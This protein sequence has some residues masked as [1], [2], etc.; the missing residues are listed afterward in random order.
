MNHHELFAGVPGVQDIMQTFARR[1]AGLGTMPTDVVPTKPATRESRDALVVGGGP[2]GMSIAN[3]LADRGAKIL[4]I[5]EGF[6]AGGSVLAMP[7]SHASAFEA[8][9]LRFEE[10]V[11]AARIELACAHVAG[12][13][14]G[15]DVLV[16]GPQGAR[17]IEARRVILCTGAHDGVVAFEGNDLPGIV[18]VRAAGRLF[19]HDAVPAKT[20]IAIVITDPS[21]TLG[22]AWAIELGARFEVNVLRGTPIAARGRSRV[23]GITALENGVSRKV[24][25]DLV[26][27]DAPV[28]PAYELCAH[29]GAELSAEPQG[30]VARRTREDGSIKKGFWAFGEVAGDPLDAEKLRQDATHMVTRIMEAT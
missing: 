14:F 15:S 6:E 21:C 22:E 24:E 12:G 27:V 9:K 7:T 13:I 29:V 19:V 1:V 2:A 17:V 18:S 23:R 8:T 10:N 30:F 3:A 28:S 20:K 4:V 5:E 25:A 26:I 11:A 16:V